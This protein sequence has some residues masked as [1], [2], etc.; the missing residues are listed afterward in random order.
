MLD[1]IEYSSKE[2]GEELYVT[3]LKS[4]LSVNIRVHFETQ[5]QEK[6]NAYL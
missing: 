2:A 5:K 3:L 6:N 1:S 4:I